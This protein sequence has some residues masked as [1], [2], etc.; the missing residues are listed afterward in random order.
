MVWSKRWKALIISLRCMMP[1]KNVSATAAARHAELFYQVCRLISLW[2][3]S[4]FEHDDLCSM[5][6]VSGT[7]QADA[8][9]S[10]RHRSLSKEIGVTFHTDTKWKIDRWTGADPCRS[11]GWRH[12]DR[13][14]LF[15]FQHGSDPS[16]WRAARRSADLYSKTGRKIWTSKFGFCLA[17]SQNLLSTIITTFFF[18]NASK[19]TLIKIS[20][21]ISCQ[22]IQR[23][24][25]SMPTK[26]ILRKQWQGMRTSKSCLISLIC[27]I[28]LLRKRNT[29]PFVNG[30]WSSWKT[31]A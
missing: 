27:R 29:M 16:L 4:R 28:N 26:P 25:W 14:R 12:V 6:K 1:F 15:C 21:S 8:P 31:W 24:I 10:R 30:S 13:S 22:K 7:C 9:F 3:P 19:K 20:I 17:L 2:R 11:F 23:S 18:S 5:P